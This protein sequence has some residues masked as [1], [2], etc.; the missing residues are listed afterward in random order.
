MLKAIFLAALL[1]LETGSAAFVVNTAAF[2]AVRNTIKQSSSSSRLF[3]ERDKDG[4]IKKGPLEFLL[5][6]K[7]TKIPPELKDEIYK[8]ESNTQAARDR[9]GRVVTYVVI[10]ILCVGCA[11][12]NVFLTELRSTVAEAANQEPGS[13]TLDDVGWGWV[14]SN[15]V[16]QFLL[17]TKIGGALAVVSGAGSAM[18]VEA[19]IDSQRAN[20]EQI[21]EELERRR[22]EQKGSSSLSSTKKK[23]S[24][25]PTSSSPS[26]KSRP[27][28]TQKKRLAALTEVIMDDPQ[29]VVPPAVTDEEKSVSAP[30]DDGLLGKL[31]GWY[32]QA[33]SMA[34][35]QALL[36]NKE[37]EDKGVLEKITDETGLRVIGKEAAAKLQQ[38]QETNER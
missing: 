21:W 35:A 18:M 27:S 9:Q 19:E 31:K 34:A 36:L 13:V 2:P 12:L 10:A 28:G 29:T 3:V 6:P 32:D 16:I 38:E 1:V 5:D 20:A 24:S 37:L 26:G 14:A 23:K 8:A 11:F 17:A 4:N 7:P 33:D 22:G 15:V 25:A 30:K